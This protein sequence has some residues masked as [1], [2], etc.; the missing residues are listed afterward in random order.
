MKAFMFIF[1]WLSLCAKSQKTPFTQYKIKPEV[2]NFQIASD[3]APVFQIVISEIMADPVP[4]NLL[5]EAEYVELFNRSNEPVQI[6]DWKILFGK[7]VRKLPIA[8]IEPLSFVII[9]SNENEQL[10]SGYGKTLPVK[11][12]PAILNEGQILT[13]KS[14]SGAVVH[15]VKFSNRWYHTSQKAHGGWSLEIIDPDNPCGQSENWSESIDSRGGTPGTVNSVDASN[16]DKIH[17]QLLRATMDSDS[18]V[19]LYFSE[20]MDSI[21]ISDPYLYST[22]KGILHPIDIHPIGPAYSSIVLS[23]TSHF[24]IPDKYMVTVLNKLKDCAGNLLEKNA[25]VNFSVPEMADSLDLVINEIM[26]D[27]DQGM[28]EYI[29]LFNNSDKVTDLANFSLALINKD[30]LNISRLVSMKGNPFL[31]FPQTYVVITRKA[32]ELPN[33][34]YLHYPSVIVEHQSLFT[35]PNEEGIISLLNYDLSVVDEFHYMQNMHNALLT[36]TKGVS[37]ERVYPDGSTND[38]GNWHSSAASAGYATPGYA[39]SQMISNNSV[40]DI[41]I[42]PEIFS[43]D[44]DGIDDYLSIHIQSVLPGI[45]ANIA[46]FNDKGNKIRTIASNKTISTDEFFIWDGNKNDH[47]AADIGMYLIYFEFFDPRGHIRRYKKAVTLAKK[48]VR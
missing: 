21:S 42:Q 39:N 35:F 23:Y 10:F 27:T 5:P 32:R 24:K 11:N 12:M 20:N 9:C 43:P 48:L 29:E 47:Q 45:V 33:N 38:P 44:N 41:I 34:S 14:S 17:P 25:L 36:E 3:Q 31:I 15:S 30:S 37:L 28:S 26:F 2:N 22:N 18:S 46:I 6:H 13:L 7:T 19:L 8:T 40:E 4:C 1:L 16:P